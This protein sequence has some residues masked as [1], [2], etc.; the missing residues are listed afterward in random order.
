MELRKELMKRQLYQSDIFNIKTG[1]YKTEKILP[2]TPKPTENNREIKEFVPNYRNIYAQLRL[3][4]DLIGQR[5]NKTHIQNNFTFSL[6]RHNSEVQIMR[7][8]NKNIRD[9][10]FDEK[11]NFSAKKRFRLE[12]YGKEGR[13]N[14]FH[15][16]TFIRKTSRSIK[17]K[18]KLSFRKN[19]LSSLNKLDRDKNSKFK[20][21]KRINSCRNLYL[22]DNSS[23]ANKDNDN[24]NNKKLEFTPYKQK[25]NKKINYK[26]QEYK[27]K[28]INKK[29]SFTNLKYKKK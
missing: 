9:N 16:Q 28:T 10:C 13:N 22:N 14:I 8:Y 25:E 21:F 26:N 24:T 27:L 12:F 2:V 6:K 4:N 5:L 15:N 3:N 11:G 17:E 29:F 19:S 23:N 1:Y 18:R 20:S 7:N